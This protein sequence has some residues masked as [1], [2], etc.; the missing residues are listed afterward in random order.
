M[1]ASYYSP[2]K[3]QLA[4]IMKNIGSL[5]KAIDRHRTKIIEAPVTL[6]KAAN[7]VSICLCDLLNIVRG[8]LSSKTW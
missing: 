4:S 8:V 2:A 1:V 6:F 3:P 7:E 5:W